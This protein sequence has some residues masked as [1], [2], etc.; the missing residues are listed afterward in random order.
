MGELGSV[1]RRQRRTGGRADRCRKR[2]QDEN[3]RSER[4]RGRDD[5]DKATC[6]GACENQKKRRQGDGTGE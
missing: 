2:I 6:M 4:K 1:G 5:E 3:G